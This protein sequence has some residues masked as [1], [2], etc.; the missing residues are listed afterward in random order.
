MEV[1]VWIHA[2]G[3]LT[4]RK[5]DPWYPL[6]KRLAVPKLSRHVWKHMQLCTFQTSLFVQMIQPLAFPFNLELSVKVSQH[7]YFQDHDPD[8]GIHLVWRSQTFRFC[9]LCSMSRLVVWRDTHLYQ[10]SKLLDYINK[11]TPNLFMPLLLWVLVCTT[12]P[13]YLIGYYHHK[14]WHIQGDF[15]GVIVG[16]QRR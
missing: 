2:P 3:A 6:N 12:L 10:F 4:P 15:C 9:E 1:S 16:N 11:R 8:R 14:K 13:P 7:F 5:E